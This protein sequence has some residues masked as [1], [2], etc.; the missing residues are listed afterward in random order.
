MH[1]WSRPYFA[2]TCALLVV[3]TTEAS[4][5][6]VELSVGGDR[7]T[8]RVFHQN[9]RSCWLTEADGS[10][11]E[12]PLDDVTGFRKLGSFR[13][14]SPSVLGDQLQ[15]EFGRDYEVA[16]TR[17]YVVVAP[18]GKAREYANLFDRTRR[19]FVLYFR[20]RGF[21]IP[22]P[23]FPLV[24]IVFATRGE[25]DEHCRGLG[26]QSNGFAGFYVGSTNH[27][28]SYE[29]DR[30]SAA[31]GTTTRGVESQ[32]HLP[33]PNGDED[34]GTQ[35]FG[36]IDSATEGILIHEATH[37]LGYNCG[38]HARLGWNPKWTVEGLATV[39]E[40]PGI[41]ESARGR[42]R[43]DRVNP[44]RLRDFRE[45]AKSRRGKDSIANLVSSDQ[46][47]RT[48][49]SDFYAESWA[50]TFFLVET[51]PREYAAYQ[52]TIAARN[53]FRRYSSEERLSDFRDA[54]G[55]NLAILDAQFLR[56]MSELD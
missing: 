20:V 54:F 3:S 56:F 45:F 35:I 46:R 32:A 19:T 9:S 18:R 1:C 22:D 6:T 8:G 41:R 37:Q 7:H 49:V 5:P 50:L 13:P 52:R 21:Q 28:V 31:R 29:I 11:T 10:I 2:L 16:K 39:F 51:R 34:P 25:F 36:S 17:D 40:A 4:D 15:R 33:R 44:Q 43:N 14:V 53:P 48:A 47:L 27:V 24:A 23:E 38:L 55:D 26:V 30:R 12:V 42:S